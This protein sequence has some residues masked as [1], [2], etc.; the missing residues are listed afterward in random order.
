[1][2]GAARPPRFA[3]HAPPPALVPNNAGRPAGDGEDVAHVIDAGRHPGGIN[4][5]VVLGPG[6][7]MTGVL[8]MTGE[9]AGAP[10]TGQCI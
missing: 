7:D 8:S 3:R 2:P 4:H 6:T 1:M 10:P 9:T 5:R